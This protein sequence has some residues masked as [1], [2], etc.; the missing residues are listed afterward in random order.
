MQAAL[1]IAGAI[2][3][4]VGLLV[5]RAYDAKEINDMQNHLGDLQ[6]RLDKSQA[7]LN[8]QAAMLRNEHH[9]EQIRSRLENHPMRGTAAHDEL[10]KQFGAIPVGDHPD[11]HAQPSSFRRM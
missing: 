6:I 8:Q 11:F 7:K 9:L 10:A 5:Q 2:G 1:A 4:G 3:F